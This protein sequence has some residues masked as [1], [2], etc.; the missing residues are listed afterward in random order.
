MFSK[1][2]KQS[3]TSIVPLKSGLF[4]P[5]LV[6]HDPYDV[7]IFAAF[8]SHSLH[9]LLYSVIFPLLPSVTLP[10]SLLAGSPMT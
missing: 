2:K 4:L 9:P 1:K 7:S 3:L 6:K 8:V 5:L 10:P